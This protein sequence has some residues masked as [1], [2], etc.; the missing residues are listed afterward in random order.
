M[1]SVNLIGRLTKD[2]D[3]RTT[4]SGTSVAVFILAVDKGLSKQ[5]REEAE[6]AGRPT[7]DFISCQAWGMTADLLT[8]YC[9][10]GSK[11]ALEGRIQTGSYQDKET[12]KTVYTTD[13]VANRVEFLDSK[14]TSSEGSYNPQ[15]R[16]QDDD[17]FEDDF[18]DQV[19][20]RSIPF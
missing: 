8:Q 15:S 1:N 3:L 5:K 18:V 11:I 14:S 6:Q 7:A 17:F 2:V 19:D 20:N 16:A 4:K 13:V 12:G 9:G 10:K